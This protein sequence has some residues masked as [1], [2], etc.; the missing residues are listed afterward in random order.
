MSSWSLHQVDAIIAGGGL[1]GIHLAL[2]MDRAGLKAIVVDHPNPTSSSRIAAGIINPI[3][4]RRFALSWMYDRLKPAFTEVYEYWEQKWGVRFF[5]PK[6]IF[7]SVPHNK[8]VN[9]LDAKL[10]DPAFDAYCRRMT[11][12]EINTA[13]EAIQFDGPGYVMRGYQLDTVGF[14]ES[15]IEYLRSKNQYLTGQI[16]GSARELATTYFRFGEFQSDKMIWANGASIVGHP[17]FEW[18]RMNPNKGQVLIA[19]VPECTGMD[20]IKQSAFYVPL[21]NHKWW[22]G[23]FDTWELDDTPSAKGRQYLL[24]RARYFQHPY[25]VVDHLAGVRPAVEDRRPVLGTHPQN[26]HLYLFNGFGSKG[27]SLI[28][29]FAQMLVGHIFDGSDIH[30]EADIKRFWPKR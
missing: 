27:T 5:Y 28:P 2:A 20:I 10:S 3:T 4:G 15:A 25:T 14:L 23:T 17:A 9:D 16:E 26:D 30:P 11:Q 29:Y 21:G 13:T 12:K 22:I 18:V 19:D 6:N 8:L 7:R 1:A 24:S